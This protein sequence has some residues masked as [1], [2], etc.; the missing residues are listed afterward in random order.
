MKRAVWIKQQHGR[1]VV[2]YA[3]CVYKEGKYFTRW[4]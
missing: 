2:L 1:K 4:E 3:V